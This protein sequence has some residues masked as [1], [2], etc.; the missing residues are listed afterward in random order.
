MS[1]NND[2]LNHLRGFLG[3]G[4]LPTNGSAK[5]N[6]G[7]ELPCCE[8][9]SQPAQWDESDEVHQPVFGSG[10]AARPRVKSRK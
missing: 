8:E 1:D 4:P 2:F 10:N 5:F 6:E 9:Y 7:D 3:Y